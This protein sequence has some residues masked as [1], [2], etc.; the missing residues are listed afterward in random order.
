MSCPFYVDRVIHARFVRDVRGCTGPRA[1]AWMN[2][3][4]RRT[5]LTFRSLDA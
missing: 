1:V 2:P 4:R 5:I 3:D